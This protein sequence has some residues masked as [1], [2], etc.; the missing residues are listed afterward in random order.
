MLTRH[1]SIICVDQEGKYKCNVAVKMKNVSVVRVYRAIKYRKK[2]KKITSQHTP[3]FLEKN[4]VVM[5]IIDIL[6]F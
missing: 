3:K 2:Q 6:I 1:G 4:V 5:M